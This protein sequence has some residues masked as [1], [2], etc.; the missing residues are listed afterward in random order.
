MVVF[1]LTRNMHLPVIVSAQR[2]GAIFHRNAIPWF[3]AGAKKRIP[4]KMHEKEKIKEEKN[5]RSSTVQF[6][7]SFYFMQ[8][9]YERMQIFVPFS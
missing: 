3:N 1:Q 5:S 6:P 8:R 9:C 7:I 4:L 2:N